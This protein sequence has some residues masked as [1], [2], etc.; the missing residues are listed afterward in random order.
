MPESHAPPSLPPC[1][2]ASSSRRRSVSRRPTP[3]VAGR[4]GSRTC[5][6]ALTRSSGARMRDR[7]RDAAREAD[8]VMERESLRDEAW[9]MAPAHG[10]GEAYALGVATVTTVGVTVALVV[11]PSWPWWISV[12]AALTITGPA[13]A[14]TR[15][16]EHTSELQSR[17][18][19]VCR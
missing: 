13:V 10:A 7:T 6:R 9:L 2:G 11:M 14:R 8:A 5:P 18:D 3:T 19:L 1:L 16:E 17:E 4:T 12:L 15:S